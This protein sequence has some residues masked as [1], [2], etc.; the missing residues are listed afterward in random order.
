MTE[1]F[2][3]NASC[4]ESQLKVQCEEV[5][6]NVWQLG[7]CSC[8]GAAHVQSWRR[9]LDRPQKLL[10]ALRM[11]GLGRIGAREEGEAETVADFM[12]LW[13][14]SWMLGIAQRCLGSGGSSWV[15]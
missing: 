10:Q 14:A 7:T 3:Q 13:L 11:P 1:K 15:G 2:P 6:P 12:L 9:D 5:T 8:P 4:L